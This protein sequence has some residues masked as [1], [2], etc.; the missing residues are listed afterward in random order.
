MFLVVVTVTGVMYAFSTSTSHV[1]P[2][3]SMEGARC[4][5]NAELHC[6]IF[7]CIREYWFSFASLGVT[8]KIRC[9]VLLRLDFSFFRVSYSVD[10]FSELFRSV[11]F[12]D[13]SARPLPRVEVAISRYQPHFSLAYYYLNFFG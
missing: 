5:V 13:L 3:P 1:S 9:F 2:T 11:P 8:A 10:L 7:C 4:T 12:F 6:A